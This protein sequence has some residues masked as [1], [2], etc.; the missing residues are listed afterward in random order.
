M[1]NGK[2][3]NI[4]RWE[5]VSLSLQIFHTESL[6]QT[7]F[8]IGVTLAIKSLKNKNILKIRESNMMILPKSMLRKY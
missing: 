1:T 6:I 4:V 7:G 2:K 5:T 8:F 3:E